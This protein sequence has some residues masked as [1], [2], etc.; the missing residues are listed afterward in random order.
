MSCCGDDDSA[1]E[2]KPIP[3]GVS[4]S[5]TPF[6][7]NTLCAPICETAQAVCLNETVTASSL[8][9]CPTNTIPGC[10]SCHQSPCSCSNQSRIGV[11]FYQTTK[12]CK[13]DNKQT[14]IIQKLVGN[15]KNK[16]AFAVPACNA[17]LRVLFDSVGDVPIGAWLWSY[18]LGYLTISGF[19]P[20]TGE[21]ELRN[22]C[23][24]TTCPGQTQAAPGTPVPACSI[25]VLLAPVCS[26]ASAGPG[27]LF[28]Y[29]N[30]GFT[31]PPVDTCID[32]AVTNVN[33]LSVGKHITINTGTY[34]I[35]AIK[36]ATL[37]TICNDGAGLTPG[38]VVNYLDGAGNLIVPI[39]VI[40]ANPCLTTPVLSATVLGCHDGQTVP[41]TALLDQQVLVYNQST[42][43]WEGK[44]LGIPT[45]VC[46]ALTF[47]LTLDPINPPATSYLVQVAD[48]SAFIV[49]QLVSIGGT[50]FTID[51]IDSATTMHMTPTIDPV[52]IVNFPVGSTLCTVSCCERLEALEDRVYNNVASCGGQWLD[53]ALRT[54]LSVPKI[55]PPALILVTQP[56]NG[57]LLSFTV[58]N[59]SCVKNL[60]VQARFTARVTF[61]VNGVAGD[62]VNISSN[63]EGSAALIPAPVASLK[64]MEDTV[65]IPATQVV[66]VK[67][68]ET[69]YVGG[70]II[71]PLE[72]WTFRSN[73]LFT[74]IAGNAANITFPLDGISSGV[75]ILGVT[76]F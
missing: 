3:Q 19:N 51:T 53:S 32:I 17:S 2:A 37:I 63:I 73:N 20:C 5:N 22:D 8:I 68:I 10:G 60:S 36:S 74:Y 62:F 65:I 75:D 18:G 44:S 39:V 61:Q 34:R 27:N 55:S 67:T 35:S 23:P 4:L 40:D 64:F 45:L 46:T 41:L 16:A 7:A 38:T 59:E 11:P 71:P 69:I 58:K 31:A 14:V 49:G 57:N 48:T 50:E 76:E 72:T 13:E 6:D 15:F 52:V 42:G 33:G 9:T 21:I 12:V 26:G 66:A 1:N 43:E 56:I 29:L 25:F 47:S 70:F 54:E 24:T 28:P 30:S